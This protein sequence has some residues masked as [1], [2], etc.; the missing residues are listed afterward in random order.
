MS[1][2][3][4]KRVKLLTLWLGLVLTIAAAAA[5]GAGAAKQA[6]DERYVRRDTFAAYRAEQAI[7]RVRDSANADA[8]WTRIDTSIAEL[9]RA[10]QHR[11]ECP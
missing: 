1:A 10:C 11:G 4:I 6:V 9:L 7:Q 2:L 8:R 3:Q 5:K